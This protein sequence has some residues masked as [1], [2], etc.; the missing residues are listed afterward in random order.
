MSGLL[1]RLVVF[2]AV[3]GIVGLWAA[4]AAHDWW[5]GDEQRMTPAV[6]QTSSPQTLPVLSQ[7][8]GHADAAQRLARALVASGDRAQLAAAE[9]LVAASL[10]LRPLHAPT[11][12]DRAALQHARGNVDAAQ[13]SI[14]I[15][16]ELWPGRPVLL[17]RAA[18][19]L[20]KTAPRDVA[21]RALMEFWAVAP[22]DAS[23][24]LERAHELTDDPDALVTAAEGVWRERPKTARADQAALMRA[25]RDAGDRV[26]AQRLWQRLPADSRAD[27]SI[28]FPSLQLLLAQGAALEADAVWQAAAGDPPGVMNGG[29]EQPLIPLGPDFQPGWAT[30]GWRYRPVGRG[31]RIGRD[32]DQAASGAFSLRIDFAG[33]DNVHLRE[34]SQVIRVRPGTRYRLRGRWSGAGLSTRAGVFI[35]LDSVAATPPIR[36]QTE[37]R[38]GSWDWTPFELD[39]DIPDDVLLLRLSVGRNRTNALDRRIAG[40]LWLDDIRLEPQE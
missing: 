18:R 30:P 11:W 9:S 25:A 13:R 22:Q 20:A 28:L 16:R 36:L 39:I 17:D 5:F 6:G 1:R 31:Y 8:W 10:R 19:L 40:T 26:L 37:A 4:A 12:L 35:A 15:A 38:W 14:A 7:V 24:I 34:P 3:A 32:A 21:L 2:A 29:F 23:R 27:E 33:T